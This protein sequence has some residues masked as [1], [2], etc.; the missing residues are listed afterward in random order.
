VSDRCRFYEYTPSHRRRRCILDEGHE[1]K[2]DLS[3]P[4]IANATEEEQRERERARFEHPSSYTDDE[5]KNERDAQTNHEVLRRIGLRNG[6][7]DYV[8]YQMDEL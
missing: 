2:H 8:Q 1:G 3:L 5:L 6:P 7:R 4:T